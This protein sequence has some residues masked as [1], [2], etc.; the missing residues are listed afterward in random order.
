MAPFLCVLGKASSSTTCFG[1]TQLV[2]LAHYLPRCVD[3]LP[4]AERPS[5]RRVSANEP[6]ARPIGE[7]LISVVLAWPGKTAFLSR[8][9]AVAARVSNRRRFVLREQFGIS[10]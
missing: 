8:G 10:S 1:T 7:Q 2:H 9:D 5:A 4:G 6:I 3:A